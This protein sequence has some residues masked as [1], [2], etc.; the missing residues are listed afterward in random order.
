MLKNQVVDLKK[1]WTE[2]MAY[3]IFQ[4]RYK[5]SDEYISNEELEL[6]F[7]KPANYNFEQEERRYL[8]NEFLKANFQS[9]PCAYSDN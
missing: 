6:I 4:K 1:I 8:Y 2:D 7:P 9:T 5:D 3:H